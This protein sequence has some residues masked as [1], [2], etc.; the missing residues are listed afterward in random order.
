LQQQRKR[1]A[2]TKAK[3]PHLLPS[4]LSYGQKFIS[5]Q[6]FLFLA[7][8]SRRRPRGLQ[9]RIKTNAKEAKLHFISDV[10]IFSL[11]LEAPFASP[12]FELRKRA[13]AF[14]WLQLQRKRAKPGQK[15]KSSFRSYF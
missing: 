7:F 13:L 6:M 1:A 8:A 2:A 3:G 4:L 12:A 9:I 5:F 14:A 15:G 10:L 11:C